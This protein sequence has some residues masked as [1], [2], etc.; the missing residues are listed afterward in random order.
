MV[1]L[2]RRLA[3]ERPRSHALTVGERTL[4]FAEVNDLSERAAHRYADLG[5]GPGDIVVIALPNSVE[6][7]VAVFAT[8]K[9]GAS[10]GPL[11][12]RLPLPERAQLVELADPRLVVGVNPSEHPARL[13]ISVRSK[14]KATHRGPFRSW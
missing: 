2:L 8:L 6:F 12:H 7:M 14:Q 5:V 11:S 13:C 1:T 3:A 4:S 10:I 9:V